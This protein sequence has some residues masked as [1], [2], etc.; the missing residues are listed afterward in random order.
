MTAEP[1]VYKALSKLDDNFTI[2]HSLPWIAAVVRSIDSSYA[3]TGEIDFIILHP[4]LGILAIEVKGGIFT[5]D[6]YRFV[7]I[8]SKQEF[9][10]IQQGRRGGFALRELVKKL[11]IP[12]KIGYAWIFPQV[13]MQ[14]KPVPPALVDAKSHERLY[15]DFLDTPNIGTRVIEIM[16][17]WQKTLGSKV[18]S[19]SQI[20]QI[21]D[22]IC[23]QEDYTPG[24]D[25]RIGVT[26]KTW[27]QLNSQQRQILE[28]IAEKKNGRPGRPG[29]GKQRNR[30]SPWPAFAAQGNEYAT[31]YQPANRHKGRAGNKATPSSCFRHSH[32]L[33]HERRSSLWEAK[34][35]RQVP[36]MVYHPK[37][38]ISRKSFPEKKMTAY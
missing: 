37:A 12:A 18:L 36:P 15:I 34:S 27:L 14:G 24:W 17:Y 13:A 23:P 2:I 25:D 31:F 28:Q 8:K 9:N 19:P 35:D 6:R 29:T 4:A 26:N 11:G 16:L 5:Y 1:L 10:P 22:A 38:G 30:R 20:D 33:S 7:Y 21:I 3:P 32:S